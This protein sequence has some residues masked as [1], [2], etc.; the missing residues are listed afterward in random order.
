MREGSGGLP[1]RPPRRTPRT[2]GRGTSASLGRPGDRPYASCEAA[3]AR[4]GVVRDRGVPAVVNGG[5]SPVVPARLSAPPGTSPRT[6]S[7]SSAGPCDPAAEWL[8]PGDLPNPAKGQSRSS[9]RVEERRAPRGEHCSPERV[10]R[11]PRAAGPAGHTWW[12]P[13]STGRPRGRMDSVSLRVRG[14]CS[15]G[16]RPSIQPVLGFLT[17]VLES[18]P[19]DAGADDD[20]CASML[21]APASSTRCRRRP[22][23]DLWPVSRERSGRR[24][25]HACSTRISCER[26]SLS[27]PTI[28]TT[29]VD[30]R[31]AS[32]SAS[33]SLS[34]R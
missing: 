8:E 17:R 25:N 11:A 10:R 23:Q 32:Q 12:G 1:A 29:S 21:L 6:G 14:R 27:S 9:R 5:T 19:C 31:K 15:G 28:C 16:A 30:G 3:V 33:N 24:K 34:G 26:L 18:A 22:P 2:L 7:R 20:G 4:C 13:W